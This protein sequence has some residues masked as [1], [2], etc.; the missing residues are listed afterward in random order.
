[1]IPL[2]D[3]ATIRSSIAA[4]SRRL[5]DDVEPK[6]QTEFAGPQGFTLHDLGWTPRPSIFTM[7]PRGR[8]GEVVVHV[9]GVRGGCAR[10]G[11]ARRR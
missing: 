8:P 3:F 4:L 7:E 1:M 10:A 6:R 2:L 5:T 11:A 9:T